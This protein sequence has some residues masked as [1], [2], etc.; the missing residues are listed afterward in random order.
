M[1]TTSE[2][3][4]QTRRNDAHSSLCMT[5]VSSRRAARWSF[6]GRRGPARCERR[7]WTHLPFEA[8]CAAQ[9]SEF[10][11][12]LWIC[13][14]AM[15]PSL[16]RTVSEGGRPTRRK[17]APAAQSRPRYTTPANFVES[18]RICSTLC[19]EPRSEAEQNVEIIRGFSLVY[20]G[21]L[22]L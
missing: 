8:F 6:W 14:Y 20:L 12:A 13:V 7:S 10:G 1:R 21:R 15:K 22:S 3:E 11:V 9:F 2:G 4:V 18:P 16:L 19:A 5:R 17:A